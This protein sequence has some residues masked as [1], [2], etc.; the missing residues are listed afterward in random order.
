MSQ[1]ELNSLAL[2]TR[3]KEISVQLAELR[4]VLHDL[5]THGPGFNATITERTDHGD[6]VEKAKKRIHDYDLE[7][8]ALS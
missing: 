8:L 6:A 7:Y 4:K 3:R 1:D 2:A 5:E